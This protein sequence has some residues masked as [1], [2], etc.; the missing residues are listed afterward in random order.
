MDATMDRPPSQLENVRPSGL[1]PPSRLPAMASSTNGRTLLETSQSDL[2]ARSTGGH[3]GL[4]APPNGTFKHK[5]PGRKG[6]AF[7]ASPVPASRPR[8]STNT[9]RNAVPEPVPKRKTLAE[10]AGETLNPLRSHMQPPTKPSVTRSDS[11]TAQVGS[12]AAPPSNIANAYHRNASIASSTASSA[13]S[14]RPPSRQ[15]APRHARM[16]SAPEVRAPSAAAAADAEEEA[17]AGVMGKRKGTPVSHL[18]TLALRKTRTHADLR[19]QSSSQQPAGMSTRSQHSGSY[20]LRSCSD[21]G[22]S[23]TASELSSRHVSDSSSTSSSSSSFPAAQQ[24]PNGGGG[25]PTRYP[26]LITAFSG[27]AITPKHRPSLDRIKE[28]VSPSKI[29]KFSCTPK[30]RHAQSAQVLQT[31]S[32][33]KHKASL[34]GLYTPRTSAKPTRE[35]PIFLTKEKLTPTPSFT[36]WDTKGRLEDMESLYAQLRGQ[37]ASAADSK[38]ALEESLGLYKS[39]GRLFAC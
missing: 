20:I 39:R 33:L 19:Q 21:G 26:S 5:I 34:N 31:P 9:N 7:E 11:N 22:A 4:M 37:F 13:S 23:T 27:L 25:Q 1:K 3:G 8:S 14:V 24:E 10:R 18:H 15:N 29:P 12:R 32:P 36:A 6:S 17:E 28:E 38:V 30:L 16:P 2:N 35:M